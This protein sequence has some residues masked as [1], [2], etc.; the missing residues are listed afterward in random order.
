MTA[1]IRK[2]R[3]HLKTLIPGKLYSAAFCLDKGEAV[4]EYLIL[5]LLLTAGYWLGKWQSR[6]CFTVVAARPQAAPRHCEAGG[7]GSLLQ[8]RTLSL[9]LKSLCAKVVSA[10]SRRT[11]PANRRLVRRRPRRSSPRPARWVRTWAAL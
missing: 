5:L 11:P 3:C 10:Q 1:T 6:D 9:E 7:R 2:L 8:L 4:V